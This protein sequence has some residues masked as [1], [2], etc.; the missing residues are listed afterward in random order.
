MARLVV[1]S[2]IEELKLTR[3]FVVPVAK[4]MVVAEIVV[5][6][7]AVGP[8][9]RKESAASSKIEGTQGIERQRVLH[10]GLYALVTR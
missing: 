7:E 10:V 6:K 5:I 3:K 1:P 8:T 9:A 4:E 2:G